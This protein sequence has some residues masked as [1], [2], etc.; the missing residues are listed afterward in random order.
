MRSS[1]EAVTIAVDEHHA[2]R[3]ALTQRDPL[4]ARR[5]MSAHVEHAGAVLFDH[6]DAHGFWR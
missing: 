1:A 3:G 6:L 2:I 4:E 5:A